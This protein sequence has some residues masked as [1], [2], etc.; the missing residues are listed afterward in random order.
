MTNLHNVFKRAKEPVIMTA[1]NGSGNSKFE[2]LFKTNRA[3]REEREQ[4]ITQRSRAWIEPFQ[5]HSEYYIKTGF[6]DFD[7][8]TG[9]LPYG[10]SVVG[11]RPEDGLTDFGLTIA[12][13]ASKGNVV[14]FVS[15]DI[16]E[17]LLKKRIVMI[18]ARIDP[19]FL[20]KYGAGSEEC[21]RAVHTAMRLKKND[22]SLY[23]DMRGLE[24]DQFKTLCKQ[25]KDRNGTN[26]VVLDRLQSLLPVGVASGNSTYYSLG[27]N[28]ADTFHQIVADYGMAL[29][30]LCE[31]KKKGSETIS[32]SHL[33][34]CGALEYG[35][36]PIIMLERMKEKSYALSREPQVSA[37]VTNN[38]EGRLNFDFSLV[39]L[40]NLGKFENYLT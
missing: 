36:G 9:G 7:H 16:K 26:L 27:R 28:I 18:D 15:P 31:A 24:L 35:A 40:D 22:F 5:R 1:S 29:L 3:V 38:L 8:H 10:V 39:Y 4:T 17:R 13:N 21:A 6:I 23:G 19:L 34:D 12:L 25:L 20:Q 37:H 11:A 30:V 14:A 2:T 33:R 32:T